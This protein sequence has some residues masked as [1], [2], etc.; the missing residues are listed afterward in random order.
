MRRT[1][2]TAHCLLITFVISSCLPDILST[3]ASPSPP[4][5]FFL[6]RFDVPAFVGFSEDFEI[7]KEIPFSYPINCGL[8]GA[9]PAPTGSVLAIE[10]SCP[11]GQSVLFLDTETGAIKLPFPSTD[12]HF[13]A[14]QSDGLAAYLKADSLG[15]PK[16]VRA[17]VS[18]PQDILA[19]S[20]FTYDLSARPASRDY[21][22]AFSRGF[23]FGSELWLMQQDTRSTLL[24]ADP[25]NYIS[26]ARFSP[27]GNQ[28][29]FIKIPDSQTPFTVGELW[30]MDADGSN[31]RKLADADAG[32]GYAANWSPDGTR[33]A[34]VVRENPEDETANQ[35]SE[36]LISNIYMIE[37]ESAASSASQA[38]GGKLTQITRFENGRAETP[39]W[40]PDGNTL[41][42]NAVV[43]GRMT[44]FLAEVESGE[45]EPLVT[46]SACCPAWMRNLESGNLFP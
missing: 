20:E 43:D 44:V 10:L 19:I 27:D 40:A 30:V 16:I 32:H 39:H 45:I 41:A 11:N 7:A 2:I 24:H 21:T 17:F 3:P 12:S 46:E 25:Y 22:F 28:I 33:I 15:N 23:G 37:V 36:A 5:P 42:F 14:W 6:Y 29:A 4:S 9:I 34:F 31:A 38:K 13:L 35:S 18:G 1:P 8:Y 26:F